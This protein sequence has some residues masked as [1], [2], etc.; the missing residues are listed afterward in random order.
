MSISY[1]LMTDDDVISVDEVWRAAITPLMSDDATSVLPR[2]ER[3]DRTDLAR[4]H[5]LISTDP[6]GSFVATQDTR[7]VGICLSS[8]RGK[9]FL[10]SRLG[11]APDFQERGIGREL[12]RMAL[13]YANGSDEQYIFTSRDPRAIHTY[14]REGFTLHPCLQ[15]VGRQYAHDQIASIRGGS[16]KDL[17]LIDAVDQETRGF[18][19][20]ADLQHW[21]EFDTSVLIDEEGGYLFF[22]GKRLLSLCATSEDI[23]ERLLSTALCGAFG[24]LPLDAHWIV[25]EQQWTLRS[26]VRSKASISIHGAMLTRN[27]EQIVVPYLPNASLG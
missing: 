6:D 4:F 14:V 9:T 16:S 1:R 10:L 17:D 19:R 21:F 11:V 24:N 8:R 23:A 2:N 12:L 22:D 27:V 20:R 13:D 26:A 18:S 3:A 7:I 15:L 25:R 5:H